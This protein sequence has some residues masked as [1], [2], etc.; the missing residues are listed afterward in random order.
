MEHIFQDMLA[1]SGIITLFTLREHFS[2][3]IAII[4]Y[5]ISIGSI[6]RKMSS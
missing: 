3:S 6:G 5:F 4:L 2:I 1:R